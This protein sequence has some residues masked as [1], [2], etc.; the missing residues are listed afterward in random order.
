MRKY[1]V[2][3]LVNPEIPD[4]EIQSLINKIKSIIEGQR[5]EIVKIED[6][7][8]KRL[9]YKVQKHTK[10]H[11]ILMHFNGNSGITAEIERFL[12]IS[13]PVM[14]FIIVKATKDSDIPPPEEHEEIHEGV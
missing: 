8:K 3:F 14:K 2:L 10:G 13:E 12:R 11:Y 7:G 4:E 6:W 9:A 1:E 5:G